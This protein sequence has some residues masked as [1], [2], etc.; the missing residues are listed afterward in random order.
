MIN[1][2]LSKAAREAG[3]AMAQTLWKD[4]HERLYD[5]VGDY[6]ADAITEIVPAEEWDDERGPTPL[7]LEVERVTENWFWI[8]LSALCLEQVQSARPNNKE[9]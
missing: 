6:L 4:E 5:Q 1:S 3:K 8:Q 9:S 7:V 2:P